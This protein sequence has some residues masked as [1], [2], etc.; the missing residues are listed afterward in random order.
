MRVLKQIEPKPNGP[1]RAL[2]G[3]SILISPASMQPAT[4][5]LETSP[6]ASAQMTLDDAPLHGALHV[7]QVEPRLDPPGDRTADGRD[8][9]EVH[10]GAD[11]EVDVAPPV[12]GHRAL[13]ERRV[14]EA[15]VAAHLERPRLALER[16]GVD[17]APVDAE[18]AAERLDADVAPHLERRR[19]QA[20]PRAD[21]L[22]E[23]AGA[24]S[25]PRTRGCRRSRRAW[26]T[27]RWPVP[28]TRRTRAALDG[29]LDDGVAV[30]AIGVAVG[31]ARDVRLA[32]ER[33]RVARLDRLPT[34]GHVGE[35]RLGDLDPADPDIGDGQLEPLEVRAL[36][37]DADRGLARDRSGSPVRPRREDRRELDV[38]RERPRSTRRRHR[39]RAAAP[40]TRR[41]AA[42]RA[43]RTTA[44]P[45]TP[46]AP[47]RPARRRAAPSRCRPSTRSGGRAGSPRPARR[48][49]RRARPRSARR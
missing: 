2:Y 48:S 8:A 46:R 40:S 33:R 36:G 19:G 20:Q 38:Q 47:R 22:E 5:E 28:R 3:S 24:R 32:V 35:A 18:L 16:I 7:E 31:L 34:G 29:Q 1:W 26:T 41:P 13:A 23:H 10:L 27:G 43:A 14:D 9:E 42:R 44:R 39:T 45:A 25:A 12:E 15:G 30:P 11:R 4:P 6:R 17:E 49:D 21:P 37:V